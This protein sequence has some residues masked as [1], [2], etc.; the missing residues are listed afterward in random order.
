MGLFDRSR[1]KKDEKLVQTA[2]RIYP[3]PLGMFGS[4]GSVSAE[5]R[6]YKSLRESVPI[7]DA[8]VCKLVRLAG[9]FS[10][11]CTDKDTEN[12]I[13]SFLK[14]VSVNGLQNGI[15]SFLNIFLDQMIIYG[16]AVGEIVLDDS[17][18]NIAALYNAS[19]DDVEKDIRIIILQMAL[20]AETG[21]ER[22]SQ[23]AAAGR[24]ADERERTQ[25]NLHATGTRTL[26]DHDIDAIVFHGRIEILFHNGAQA[27]DFV[28]KEH[29]S[30]FKGSQQSGQVTR[31]VENRSGSNL[32]VDTQFRSDDMGQRGLAQARRAVEQDMVERLAPEQRRFHE[33]LEVFEHLFLPGELFEIL[34][35]D[36]F[37]EFTFPK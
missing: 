23:Q 24:S 12:D 26:V 5:H 10:V 16:T 29:V 18:R 11:K 21:P 7:V 2:G 25:G 15:D 36:H 4:R 13:N 9:G 1:K 32:Q 37:V 27:V 14:N 30:F 20:D 33:D 22:R 3:Q 8:A 6:L 35:T 28:N 31:F 34:R 17:G 19:L